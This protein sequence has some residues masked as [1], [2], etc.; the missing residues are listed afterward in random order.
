MNFPLQKVWEY[1]F[2]KGKTPASKCSQKPPNPVP[3]HGVDFQDL[4]V[5]ISHHLSI[6]LGGNTTLDECSCAL[7]SFNKGI[8]TRGSNKGCAV[9]RD[10]SRKE[11]EDEKLL[12]SLFPV[13]YHW[14]ETQGSLHSAPFVILTRLEP[15]WYK[16]VEHS[17]VPTSSLS[18]LHS[19]KPLDRVQFA[20][21]LQVEVKADP[22]AGDKK[23]PS[24]ASQDSHS[25]RSLLGTWQ[26]LVLTQGF[27]LVPVSIS[28]L[29]YPM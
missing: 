12:P 25:H 17:R 29:E 5:S 13:S 3:G 1:L 15:M 8:I 2:F 24:R 28:W 19:D 22:T 16:T 9:G 6:Q 10:K 4:Q 27:H 20:A 18:F 7:N 26:G 23:I 21:G 14:M 11:Y